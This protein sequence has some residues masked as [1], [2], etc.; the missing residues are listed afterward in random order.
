MLIPILQRDVES[1]NKQENEKEAINEQ[2]SKEK[3]KNE[4]VFL[5]VTANES[6]ESDSG[7]S[8]RN[9]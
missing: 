8:R 5:T 7:D 2:S 3:Q 4:K 9:E 1:D 6:D